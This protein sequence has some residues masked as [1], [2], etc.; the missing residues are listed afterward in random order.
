VLQEALQN[1]VKHSAARKFTV[2]LR[3]TSKEVQ[4]TVSDL[5]VG[6]NPHDAQAQRGLGL[7]SMRERLELVDGEL[8][9]TSQPGHGTTITARAPLGKAP[10]LLATG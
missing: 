7:I 10:Q 9:I 4:L 3:G 2:D 1:A 6:F 8:S 5:G